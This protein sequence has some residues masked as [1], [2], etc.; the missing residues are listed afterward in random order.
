MFKVSDGNTKRTMCEICPKLII[1][2]L[3]RR[4]L[5]DFTHYFDVCIFDL[6]QVN[7]DWDVFS[8]S[9]DKYCCIIFFNCAMCIIFTD[10]RWFSIYSFKGRYNFVTV[11]YNF[12][13]LGGAISNSLISLLVRSEKFNAF[14]P[15]GIYL[16]KVN[17]GNSAIICEI[18]SKLTKDTRTML[19]TS[20]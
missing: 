2:T 14:F 5:T 18:C 16:F 10:P 8:F 11:F 6:E 19:L 4:H 13:H 20:L 17:N 7:G 15:A 9:F 3:E 1:K 12:F